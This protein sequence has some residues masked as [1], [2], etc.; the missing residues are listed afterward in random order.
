MMFNCLI[1]FI[2]LIAKKDFEVHTGFTSNLAARIQDYNSG[3]T[4]S[5]S[6]RS[7]PE[8][9]FCESYFIEEYGR[10]RELYSK[11]TIGKKEKTDA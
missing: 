2:Y 11:T 6:Y 7:S 10:K 8:L 5:S 3:G 1:V 4:K 9:I